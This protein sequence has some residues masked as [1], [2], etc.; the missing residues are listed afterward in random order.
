MKMTFKLPL[1]EHHP[2]Q[3]FEFLTGYGFIELVDPVLAEITF[4]LEDE[5]LGAL[6]RRVDEIQ[7]EVNCYDW[8][9]EKLDLFEQAQ[10]QIDAQKVGVVEITQTQVK[11]LTKMLQSVE[12]GTVRGTSPQERETATE[13]LATLKAFKPMQ[14]EETV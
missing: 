6:V 13:L 14:V 2:K 9:S 10:D 12:A 1:P 5:T 8:W 7:S 3:A 11:H 4:S